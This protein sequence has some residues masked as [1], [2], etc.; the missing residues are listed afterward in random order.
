MGVQQILYDNRFADTTALTASTQDPSDTA[1]VVQNV[2]DLRPYTLW[3]SG[4]ST[5]LKYITI[6]CGTA[7][8]ADAVA[9]CGHNLSSITADIAVQHS[10]D[11][12][13]TI[14]TAATYTPTNDF[15]FM[16]TFASTSN[17]YWRLAINQPT[18]AQIKIGVVMI[19]E[20]M[21]FERAVQRGYDPD[22]YET[23]V[24]MSESKGLYPLGVDVRG[25]MRNMKVEVN[26]A[27]A[28]FIRDKF[29]PA[30]DN[31]IG[32]CKPFFYAWNYADYSSAVYYLQVT[33]PVFNAAYLDNQGYRNLSFSA[34]GRKEE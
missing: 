3:K 7:K 10:S 11:T 2:I 17:R 25:K 4:T 18:S 8:A 27:S 23:N 19:G 16:T 15:A 24:N 1:A 6:D 32:E 34:R 22:S 5:G 26:A 33:N 21:Q 31:H 29:I 30:W 13:V 12:F 14:T 20:R 28:T 9:I